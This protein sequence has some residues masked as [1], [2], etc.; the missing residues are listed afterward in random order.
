M[1][2]SVK[3]AIQRI[4]AITELTGKVAYDHFSEAKQLPFAVYTYDFTTTGAD[5]YNGVQ[6]ID[7]SIEL[8]SATRNFS[9]EE[10]I[11]KA[12][13]D[14]QITSESDYISDERMYETTFSFTFPQK[15]S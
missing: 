6:M 4:E 5:D 11:I 14:V 1:I 7:F 15:I 12:F 3:E 13:I 2:Q 8:Y 10:K 9:L